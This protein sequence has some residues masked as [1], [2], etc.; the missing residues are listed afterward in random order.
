MALLVMLE[1][2]LLDLLL[3]VWP[4][5]KTVILRGVKIR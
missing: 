1:I 5:P 3:A 4:H 2:A